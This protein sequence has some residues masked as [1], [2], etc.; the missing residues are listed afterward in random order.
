M[1]L[2]FRLPTDLAVDVPTDLSEELA[3]A[4]RLAV[5]RAFD[6]IAGAWKVVVQHYSERGRWR[7]ELHGVTGRHVWTVLAR[8][9]M[10]PRLVADK[11]EA[12]LWTSSALQYARIVTSRSAG[13]DAALS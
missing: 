8:P 9:E 11:L 7:I 2:T 1:V 12:F 13:P 6:H 4:I 5:R 10:L 3:N